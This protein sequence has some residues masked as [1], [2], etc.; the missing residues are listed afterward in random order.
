MLDGKLGCGDCKYYSVTK[1]ECRRSCPVGASIAAK[2]LD[3]NPIWH[4]VWPKVK[5][6]DW[7]GEWEE[8]SNG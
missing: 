8:V 7:C 1:S 4:A 3:E 6:E 2:R 5:I